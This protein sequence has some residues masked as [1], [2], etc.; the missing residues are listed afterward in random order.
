MPRT[1]HRDIT[2]IGASAGGVSALRELFCA[3]RPDYPAA[4]F[5]VLHVAPEAPSVLPEILNRASA[6]PAAHA[7][8][9]SRICPGTITVAAPDLHL[10]L[11]PEGVVVTHGPR[12]NRHRPS[13]DVLFRS[14][15]V[16]FGPR[17]TGVVLS[18]M[19]DDGTAGLWAIKHRGGTAVVQD[20]ADAEF[21]DM[22]RNAIEV[23]DV[24]HCVSIRD[25]A[26]LLMRIVREPVEVA[27]QEIPAESAQSS[28]SHAETLRGLLA[29]KVSLPAGAAAVNE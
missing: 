27:A 5:V 10:M 11:R 29:E 23:V 22:P 25:M 20:P 1:L 24:D 8:T 13:I 9:G 28:A 14:A 15:A 4:I 12:E 21:P 17:V 6:L 2:V 26:A 7:R 3:L 16:A 18:G 19:L